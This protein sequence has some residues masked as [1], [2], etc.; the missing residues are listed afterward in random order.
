MAFDLATRYYNIDKL[1]DPEDVNTNKPDKKSIL[2]YVMCLYHAIDS[3]RE[4]QMS[5]AAGRA[6]SLHMLPQH[7]DQAPERQSTLIDEELTIVDEARSSSTSSKTIDEEFDEIYHAGNLTDLDEISLAKSIEDLSKFSMPTNIKRSSTFTITTNEAGFSALERND[8][9]NNMHHAIDADS[10]AHSIHFFMDS[11]SRPVSIATNASTEIGGYQNAIEMVLA[12]LL[13]AEEVLAKELPAIVDVS[14]ARD[15]FTD[16]EEFMVKLSEYQEY[17]GGALEEGARLLTESTAI[18]GLNQDDQTEIKKQMVLLNE[19]WEALRMRALAVQSRVHGKLAELQLQKIEEL[20][21]L[22]TATE[23]KI[24]RMAEIDARPSAMRAQYDEHKTLEASLSEQKALVDELGNLVVIVNDDSFNELEDKLAA[25]GERWSHVVKWTKIRF[26]RLQTTNWQWRMLNERYAVV[27]QWLDTRENDLKAMEQRPVSAIGD[28]MERMNN[29]RYCAR[30]LVALGEHLAQLQAI[31][32]ELQAAAT[33]FCSKLEALED[34]AEALKE[35]VEVQQQ[36]IQGM[37]FNF[38]F[39]DGHAEDVRMPAGWTDFQRRI[40]QTAR[41]STIAL[42]KDEEFEPVSGDEM[43]TSPQ[44]NKKR[45]MQKSEQRQ[46]LDHH[47]TELML[48]VEDGERQLRD[49]DEVRTLKAEL[50]SLSALE[51]A[52]R[53]RRVT[54]KDALDLVEKCRAAGDDADDLAIVSQ[55][56]ITIGGRCDVLDTRVTHLLTI[57]KANA[58]KEKFYRNLTGFKLILADCQDWFKQYANASSST[59]DE[60]KNRLSYM[61]SLN[62]EIAEAKD[63][64]DSTAAAGMHEWKNDFHQFFHSWTDIKSAITRLIETDFGAKPFDATTERLSLAM[65]DLQTTIEGL[66]VLVTT[67]DTMTGNLEHLIT[68]TSQC[69]DVKELLNANDVV[70]YVDLHVEWERIANTLKD[71]VIKQTAAIE[72]ANHFGSEYDNVMIFLQ[73]TED[74]LHAD[75]FIFGESND[76]HIQHKDYEA[77]DMDMKKIE[78]DIISVRN[79]SELI[80]KASTD[81]EYTSGLQAQIMA[82][83][84]RLTTVKDVL[85]ARW[86]ELKQTSRETE[87]L[88]RQVKDTD[89]WLSELEASVPKTENADIANAIELFQLKSKF[90]A[91]K[92]KCEQKAIDFRQLNETGSERLMQIDEQLSRPTC[93]RKYSSLAKQFTRLNAR[94]TDVT[95]LVYTRAAL[96]E[97]VSG[98]LGELKTLIVSETGYLDKLEKCLRKSPENAADAEEIYE[99]LDVSVVRFVSTYTDAIAFGELRHCFGYAH[100]DGAAIHKY[101]HTQGSQVLLHTEQLFF[102][103]HSQDLENSIRNH[104]EQR[105]DKIRGLSNELIE[106]E[107]MAITIAADVNAVV[108]RW[109]AL[110]SQVQNSIIHNIQCLSLYESSIGIFM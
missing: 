45:R 33:T 31:G 75:V 17:V 7:S 87:Q 56:L 91:W 41:K 72:N 58:I 68:A 57:N 15:Q 98:Q 83:N 3:I 46:L 69:N 74:K 8:N 71:R 66:T 67:T 27:R 60:L 50:T 82:L 101:T 85:V 80:L 55:S 93:H 16:H 81:Q 29:L 32:Q 22:L 105:L 106:H 99:E 51:A 79:F 5:L 108:D 1:L 94:W 21:V 110:L 19:R 76:L 14:A 23:D 9:D 92:E 109:N 64:G 77:H 28:V 90:Q 61:D 35:I 49:A 10:A 18:T 102:F 47:V 70:T 54:H 63:F 13:E 107:C 26:E 104:S 20:R 103:Y 12:L 95:V 89:A 84:A 2:M 42:G 34:R 52:I 36:R 62:G 48:F 38:N 39:S 73:R 65:T 88:V 30:D 44:S 86:V 100:G 97:H 78:I 4:Q 53:Q 43:E 37:G 24:S 6:D 11:R 59:T 40:K 25:L 96:L